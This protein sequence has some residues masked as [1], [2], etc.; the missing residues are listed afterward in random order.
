MSALQ[1]LV[2][3]QKLKVLGPSGAGLFCDAE[4]CCSATTHSVASPGGGGTTGAL[5][6][7]QALSPTPGSAA[8][9][10]SASDCHSMCQP[11][12]ALVTG[13][14]LHLGMHAVYMAKTSR[15][16]ILMQALGPEYVCT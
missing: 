11:S 14:A 7:R 8:L 2:G 1:P 5:R 15:C 12:A 9:H 4:T 13:A 10:V 6:R 16:T 3:V